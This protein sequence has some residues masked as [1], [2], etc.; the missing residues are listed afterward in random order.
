MPETKFHSFRVE[1][2]VR[3]A[4]AAGIPAMRIHRPEVTLLDVV[5]R[6]GC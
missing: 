3:G 6:L 4:E 1:A 5:A 2:D